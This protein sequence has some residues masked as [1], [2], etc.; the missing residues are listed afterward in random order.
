MCTHV[1]VGSRAGVRNCQYMSPFL[2]F[3][4]R[5]FSQ[6]QGFVDIAGLHRQL[7]LEDPLPPPSEAGVTGGLPHPASMYMGSRDADSRSDSYAS[8][9]VFIL[10]VL[11]FENNRLHRGQ[12]HFYL[13]SFITTKGCRRGKP[14]GL[15]HSSVL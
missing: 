5:S 6:T 8:A 13:I 15:S 11:T 4:A 7:A 12:Q 9:W 10:R 14:G 1:H 3:E 2:F